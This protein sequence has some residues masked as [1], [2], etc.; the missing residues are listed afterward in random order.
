MSV[1]PGL[2]DLFERHQVGSFQVAAKILL[3]DVMAAA[4]SPLIK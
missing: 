3:A 1:K 4:N 2:L